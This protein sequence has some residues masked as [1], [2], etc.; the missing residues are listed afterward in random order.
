MKLTYGIL[1]EQK[2]CKMKN[3][4]YTFT[5]KP[6]LQKLE[7]K[8]IKEVNKRKRNKNLYPG[9]TRTKFI[10]EAIEEKLKNA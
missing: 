2:E 3:N 7:K 4:M 8:F 10:I 6:E 5:F 1:T 9:Y